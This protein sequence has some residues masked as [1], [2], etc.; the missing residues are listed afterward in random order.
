ML[1]LVTLQDLLL[2]KNLERVHLLRVFLLHEQNFT[3]GALT[4]DGE[5][6]EVFG[7]D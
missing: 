2:L 3:I 5:G 1:I 7:G 6:L 4:N